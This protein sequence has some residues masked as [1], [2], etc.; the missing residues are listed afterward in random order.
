MF[1]KKLTLFWPKVIC[2]FS[3]E[4]FFFFAVEDAFGVAKRELNNR[5]LAGSVIKIITFLPSCEYR[6][7][8]DQ[9]NPD[10]PCKAIQIKHSGFWLAIF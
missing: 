1:Q 7:G 10:F 6:K 3:N 2:N 4:G 8:M 9:F 5:I